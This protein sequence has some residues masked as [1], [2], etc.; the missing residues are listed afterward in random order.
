MANKS[1]RKS[2]V[3]K[4]KTTPKNSKS[5]K[6]TQTVSTRK[7]AQNNASKKSKGV[8]KGQVTIP[9]NIDMRLAVI[10]GRYFYKT[11]NADETHTYAVYRDP[12]SKEVRAV[13][14]T[15]LYKPDKDRMEDLHKGLL[16]KVKFAGYE[17]PSGVNNKYYNT[18][19]Q[20]KPI[21]LKHADIVSVDKTPLSQS[22]AKKIFAFAKNK[23]NNQ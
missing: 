2:N 22:I 20:G 16:C 1:N 19:I 21:D 17:T 14:T 18:N 4:S 8:V 15:H 10:K 9:T 12:K 5:N 11:N 7:S 3:S 23:R 6:K 13:Q